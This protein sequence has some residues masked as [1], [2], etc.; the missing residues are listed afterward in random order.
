M[1][2]YRNVLLIGRTGQGKS[3]LAN[4]IVNDEKNFEEGGKFDE[5][6]EKGNGTLSQTKKTQ[7]KKITLKIEVGGEIKDVKYQIIDTVGFDDTTLSKREVLIEVAKA[8]KKVKEGINQILFVCGEKL[9]PQEID[10]Y[11]ILRR[12]L[13]DEKL[14]KDITKYITIIRTK[15]DNFDDEDS[16]KCDIQSLIENESSAIVEMIQSCDERVVHINNPPINV[17]GKEVQDLININKK[18]CKSARKKV[19]DHLA[20]CEDAYKPGSLD[21]INERIGCLLNENK[22]LQK[23][24]EELQKEY[25]ILREQLNKSRDTEERPKEMSFSQDIFNEFERRMEENELKKKM[26]EMMKKIDEIKKIN[27]RK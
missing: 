19:I 17:K 18:I 20:T 22:E 21:E 10:A 25:N 26:D 13:F 27:K 5:V 6:F 2:E 16:C 7:S 8:C 9:T 1:S 4:L 23:Q 14:D 11:N 24:L 3:S 12:V 15:F